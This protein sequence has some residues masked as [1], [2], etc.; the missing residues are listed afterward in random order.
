[1]RLL[2][3]H[4]VR[5]GP[6]LGAILG[7]VV[8]LAGFG[9]AYV[10]GTSPFWEYPPTDFSFHLI[11]WREFVQEPWTYPLLL[12]RKLEEPE[13]VNVLYMDSLPLVA[14]AAKA[15]RGLVPDAGRTL[16]LN[17]LGWWQLVSYALQGAFAAL[18]ARSLRANLRAQIACAAV[19]VSMQI[20]VTRFVH[21]ALNSHFLILAALWLYVRA[22]ERTV[23]A[24]DGLRVA[25]RWTLLLVS[26]LL[27]HPYLFAMAA[28]V[29]GVTL[30]RWIGAR[31]PALAM[32]SGALAVACVVGVM[33]VCG[34]FG[35]RLTSGSDWGFGHKSTDLLSFFVPQ[36]SPF[37]R[38]RPEGMTIDLAHDEGA[39]GYDYLGGGL[40]ALAVI[41]AIRGRAS[42]V[43]AVRR[44]K[45]LAALLVL[46]TL[47]AI[48]NR[49]AAGGQVLLELP[50]PRALS[51]IVGQFRA[52]GRFIWPPTYAG[53]LYTVVLA[54][55]HL[56]LGWSAFVPPV[57]VLVQ[58][59]DGMGNFAWV[60]SY[61]AQAERRW[62]DW[63]LFEPIVA[64]H[65]GVTLRPSFSCIEHGHGHAV[66]MQLEI[67]TMAALRGVGLSGV[68]SSRQVVDCDA[69]AKSLGAAIDPRRLY[70]LFPP[71]VHPLETP[72]F[73]EA[74][75]PCVT[76]G[77]PP[78]NGYL[79]SA[80]M[81]SPPRDLGPAPA[82][83]LP[84]YELGTTIRLGTDEV[85]PYLGRGWSHAEGTFRW[86]M[87]TR[88]TL[89]LPL[90]EPLPAGATLRFTA[91]A[92]VFP[93]RP[94]VVVDVS[95]NGA[96]VATIPM[97]TLDAA[98]FEVPIPA[99]DV[100]RL[101]I[102][103]EVDSVRSP[104]EL[105]ANDDERR[106]GIHVGDVAVTP[107]R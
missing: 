74:G 107:P 19:A 57:L 18:V 77:A 39:E 12:S 66:M 95:V 98:T 50:V 1:M 16:L 101:A 82:S 34:Y 75:A 103:F 96:R 7:V 90:E 35:P 41:A 56:R 71:E 72:R 83:A 100:A 30:V 105:G 24:R 93:N 94:R 40:V 21:T 13:G 53:A 52:S 5:S 11:G 32:T 65:E 86:T 9:P 89:F 51:W 92:A 62:L 3:E 97:T 99:T 76:F 6:L 14:L 68:A 27:L 85:A 44:H 88:A 81:S 80:K 67:E 42:V 63:S 47:F 45:A 8:A 33:I 28:L 25:A 79:C 58:F 64:A 20:F 60:R 15:V 26:A 59:V 87:A 49:V 104:R 2:L 31:R 37:V 54:F 4:L 73:A 29:F 17:P 106:L 46:M 78:S 48:S 23:R 91:G 38:T 70:V 55:R 22:G 69:E 84:R 10:F 102:V 36:H 61:T 43:T